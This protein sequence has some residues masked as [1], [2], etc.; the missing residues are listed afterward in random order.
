LSSWDHN[1]WYHRQVLRRVPPGGRVLEVGCGA[2]TLARKLASRG[3]RVDAVDRSA[4]MVDAARRSGADPV[5]W[6]LGDV[7][8]EPLD[9][10]RYDAVTSVSVLHHLPL[11]QAL[12]RFAGLLRPGGVLVAVAVPRIAL[13]RELVPEF[14]AIIG[15]RMV[16][17]VLTLLRRVVP[18][19]PWLTPEPTDDVMPVADGQLTVR[20]VRRRAEAVLPGVRVRRLVFWR[21]LLVWVRPASG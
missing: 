10:G 5:R 20:E 2:G 12:T 15:H 16:G 21:Y 4:K 19:R 6:I 17:L 18:A 11:E 9:T 1:A 8:T 7:L 3:C 13:P 14:V